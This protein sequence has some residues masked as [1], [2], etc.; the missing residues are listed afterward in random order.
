MRDRFKEWQKKKQA[1][2]A[3]SSVRRRSS[4]GSRQS[5]DFSDQSTEQL[6]ARQKELLSQIKTIENFGLST[7]TFEKAVMSGFMGVDGA[8]LKTQ[9]IDEL[10]VGAERIP[11]GKEEMYR[12]YNGEMKDSI[13]V[14]MDNSQ[15]FT[16]F[17]ASALQQAGIH[18]RR[19][20]RNNAGVL[21]DVLQKAEKSMPKEELGAMINRNIRVFNKSDVSDDL[22]S[23]I[24]PIIAKYLRNNI[25]TLTSVLFTEKAP[26]L[27][28]MKVE[29]SAIT[30]EL[31]QRSRHSADV[32]MGGTFEASTAT[33]QRR[34]NQL[35]EQLESGSSRE[36]FQK[37]K[38]LS[39]MLNE[40]LKSDDFHAALKSSDK[41]ALPLMQDY[42]QATESLSRLMQQDGMNEGAKRFLSSPLEAIQG[43][44]VAA[45]SDHQLGQS[46]EN[47]MRDQVSELAEG[48]SA[49]PPDAVSPVSD[50]QQ[51]ALDTLAQIRDLR[52]QLEQR[53][54]A[55]LESSSDLS[56]PE[57]DEYVIQV[58][59]DEDHDFDADNEQEVRFGK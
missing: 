29:S 15:V 45:L 8:G 56:T 26:Q 47:A 17:L 46:S 54:E 52:M 5:F 24:E 36:L 20:L 51:Q 28:A 55:S 27:K 10:L 44:L 1:Q 30:R 19:T 7:E 31:G 57:P 59:D 35:I 39:V 3:A 4:L 58:E 41:E 2:R 9:F 50:E 38:A 43:H 34:M 37:A 11:K 21:D 42:L 16:S 32:K 18:N 6:G 48:P 12:V 49:P 22:T 25:E 40:V 33:S 14:L 53:S 13:Q 23:R